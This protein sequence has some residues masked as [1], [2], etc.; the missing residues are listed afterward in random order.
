M[1][2]IHH[3]V[4]RTRQHLAAL[5]PRYI[6]NETHPAAI[7]LSIGIVQSAV[8]HYLIHVSQYAIYLQNGKIAL[9]LIVRNC[10]AEPFPFDALVPDEALKGMLA[11]RLG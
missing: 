7:P 10:V 11:E 6:C 2:H 4:E 8:R 1:G 9:Q 5:G 3:G